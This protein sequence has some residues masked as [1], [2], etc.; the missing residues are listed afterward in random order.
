MDDQGQEVW[1]DLNNKITELTTRPPEPSTFSQFREMLGMA[2]TPMPR[3]G[4]VTLL[5]TLDEAMANYRRAANCGA[6][7]KAVR[8][9]RKRVHQ[10]YPDLSD[11][12]LLY[13]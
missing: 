12:G 7:Q 4:C 10:H 1:Q 3:E 8:I 2:G 11:G 13:I 5:S 9:M 6:A